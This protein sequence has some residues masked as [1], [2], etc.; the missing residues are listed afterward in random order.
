MFGIAMG[1]ALDDSENFDL[2][3]W[4]EAPIPASSRINLAQAYVPI[5]TIYKPFN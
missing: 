5:E 1:G 2:L 3:E 4:T